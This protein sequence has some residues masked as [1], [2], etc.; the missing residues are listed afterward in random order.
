MG[1]NVGV[2]WCVGVARRRAGLRR[3]VWPGG[4]RAGSG[5]GRAGSGPEAGRK[6]AAA[7]AVPVAAMSFAWPWQY[8]FPPFF[9]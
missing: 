7:A 2:V 3:G 4:G 8:S 1:G 9:T 5:M 6:T